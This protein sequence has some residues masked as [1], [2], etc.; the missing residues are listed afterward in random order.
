VMEDY[1]EYV[2]QETDSNRD[3]DETLETMPEDLSQHVKVGLKGI[4]TACR[5]GPAR[6]GV[7][8]E[9]VDQHLLAQS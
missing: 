4:A 1:V 8:G 2:L 7:G 3:L 6:G 5:C 9:K